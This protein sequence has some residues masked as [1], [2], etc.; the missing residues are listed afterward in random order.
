MLEKDTL[1]KLKEQEREARKNLI[2]DAAERVFA[3]KPYNKVSLREI[4]DEAGIGTSS[5]YTYFPNQE[6]LFVE[7]LVR[8]TTNLLNIY[9]AVVVTATI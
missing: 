7:T 6:T 4:A 9:N 2:M 3:N 5:I 8:E 1:S